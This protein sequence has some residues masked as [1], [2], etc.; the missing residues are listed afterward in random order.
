MHKKYSL[1]CETCF[2]CH[3][4]CET[5]YESQMMKFRGMACSLHVELE[6]P[7]AVLPLYIF[8]ITNC[9]RV[10]TKHFI[11]LKDP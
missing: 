4:A 11:L 3:S 5:V 6:T 10:S 7:F 2:M 8:Q 1:Q 9:A